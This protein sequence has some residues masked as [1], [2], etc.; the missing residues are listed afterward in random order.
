MATK[1]ELLEQSQKAIGD[2][3]NLSKYLLG[4]DAPYDVN[5]IP[6]DSPFYKDAK[7]IS[8]EMD[9]D[10]DNMSHEDSNRVMLN[11][12]SEYFCNIKPEEKY[13]AILTISFKKVE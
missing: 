9:L 6:C 12:L 13:D 7:A 10:W 3:F 8:E 1:K 11:L 4:E 5:E 2:F